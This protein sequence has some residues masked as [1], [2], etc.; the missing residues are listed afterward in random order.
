MEENL[1]GH[2]SWLYWI[3]KE[4]QVFRPQLGSAQTFPAS[5]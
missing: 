5:A 3:I 2:Y 4:R 1:L